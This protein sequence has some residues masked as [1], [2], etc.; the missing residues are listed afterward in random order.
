MTDENIINFIPQRPPI[1]MVDK[2]ITVVGDD[3]AKCSLV[4]TSDNIFLESTGELSVAGLVEHIAQSASA[5]FGY[6]AKRAGEPHVP[7]AYIGEVKKLRCY[8]QPLVGEEL[9]TTVTIGATV[10]DVTLLSAQVR[11]GQQ[12]ITESLMKIGIVSRD[13]CDMI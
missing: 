1:V 11:V 7:L 2:I 12:L 4:I 3:G 13:Y 6:N 5:L 10:G 9:V 8:R